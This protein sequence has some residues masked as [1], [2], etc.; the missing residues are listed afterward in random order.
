VLAFKPGMELVD[1]WGNAEICYRPK[2]TGV[3]YSSRTQTGILSSITLIISLWYISAEKTKQQKN[4]W[5]RHK[6]LLSVIPSQG[7]TIL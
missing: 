3:A 7:P 5:T 2:F 6:C 4:V 1:Y